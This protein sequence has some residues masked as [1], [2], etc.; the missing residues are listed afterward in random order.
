[1]EA[2]V[3]EKRPHYLY[4]TPVFSVLFRVDLVE[5]HFVLMMMMM[6]IREL[7]KSKYG[8]RHSL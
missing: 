8:A 5:Q 6:M 2:V 4:Q 7:L 1:M 3:G